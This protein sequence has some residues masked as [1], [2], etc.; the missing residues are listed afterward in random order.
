MPTT[1]SHQEPFPLN[2][3]KHSINWR[4]IE[5]PEG[6][7]SETKFEGENIIKINCI[8]TNSEWIFNY[9]VWTF[10]LKGNQIRFSYF[11]I[12]N[13]SSSF[14]SILIKYLTTISGLVL[15]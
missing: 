4:K 1:S 15:V 9:L 14:S 8:S 12:S 11:K 10:I 13:W 3:Q 6:F 5:V 7:I 2:G